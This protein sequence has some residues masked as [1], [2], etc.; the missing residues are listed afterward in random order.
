MK[1]LTNRQ[2]QAINTRLKIIDAGIDLFKYSDFGDVKIKDICEKANISVGTFYHHFQSKEDVIKVSYEKIDSLL[3][4]KYKDIKFEDTFKTIYS[5]IEESSQITISYGYK[6]TTHVYSTQ[7][8]I[9]SKYILDENRYLYKCLNETLEN[10][11]NKKEI[12]SSLTSKEITDMI[13]RLTRG[14]TFDWCLHEGN[15]NLIERTLKDLELMLT[16][17]KFL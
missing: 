12:I 2:K 11:L 4:D 6:L 9:D 5:L 8:T 1:Q 3:K 14:V 10:G 7:L 16:N 15:Y 13:M 17:F